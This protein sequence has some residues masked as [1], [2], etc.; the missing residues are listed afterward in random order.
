MTANRPIQSILPLANPSLS[1]TFPAHH[2]LL[3]IHKL[4]APHTLLPPSDKFSVLRGL[5]SSSASTGS[6]ENNLAFKCTRKRLLFETLHLDL[7]G[8]VGERRT[9]PSANALV[10]IEATAHGHGHDHDPTPLPSK[11]AFAAVEVELEVPMT[12]GGEPRTSEV[13]EVEKAAVT[14]KPKKPK[15]KVA[16]H[17]DRPDL[18]DF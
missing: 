4:P 2:G 11:A 12:G 5:S 1:A 15:K 6:G 18:Y 16:F 9:T 10:G 13:R 7:D 17:S 14:M 3:K 8:G